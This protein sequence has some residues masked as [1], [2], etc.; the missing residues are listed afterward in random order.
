LIAG[1]PAFAAQPPKHL[2]AICA[3]HV[4]DGPALI[5]TL[6]VIRCHNMQTPI[7]TATFSRLSMKTSADISVSV[8]NKRR[9]LEFISGDDESS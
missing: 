8:F 7:S 9:Q 5:S 3:V 2:C 6:N 4:A 1:T